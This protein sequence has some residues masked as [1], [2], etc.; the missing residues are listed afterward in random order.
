M[1][2]I[3]H[4]AEQ[5]FPPYQVRAAGQDFEAWNGGVWQWLGVRCWIQKQIEQA[6]L[7]L[8]LA[9]NTAGG[10]ALRIQV[11]DQRQFFGGSQ[12]GGKIDDSGGFANPPLLVGNRNN[13]RPI[14]DLPLEMRL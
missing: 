6:R 7:L 3:R 4:L 9:G 8:R 10:I 2:W 1:G 12:A 14:P 5:F 11:D 13:N